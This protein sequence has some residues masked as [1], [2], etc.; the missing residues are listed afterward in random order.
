MKVGQTGLFKVSRGMYLTSAILRAVIV[1][2]KDG[3]L[4]V[5]TEECDRYAVPEHEFTLHYM[6]NGIVE[7]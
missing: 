4:V 1:D 3:I 7:K 2:I 5:E 6:A